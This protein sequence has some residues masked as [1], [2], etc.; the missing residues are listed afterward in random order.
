MVTTLPASYAT[1]EDVRAAFPMINSITSITSGDILYAIGRAQA[2]VAAKLSNY[3]DVKSLCGAPVVAL[4][5]T[6]LAVYE[7]IG[8]RHVHTTAA[9]AEDW[10][11]KFKDSIGLL[12]AIMA[13]T[14]NVV[15]SNGVEL[16]ASAIRPW[17]NTMANSATFSETSWQYMDVDENKL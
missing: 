8:K 3:Y 12:D 2:I 5:T 7:I 9:K 10:A 13:G 11:S 17:S 1:V 4:I 6:D 15:D 16:A 14:I